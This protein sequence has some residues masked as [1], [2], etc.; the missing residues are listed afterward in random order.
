MKH[1]DETWPLKAVALRY[2]SERE[3]APRV[4]AKGER[5][6][7]EK[8][9]AIAQEHHIHVYEDPD[10]VALLSRLDVEAEIPHDLFQ[11]VAEVLAFVYRLN[12]RLPDSAAPG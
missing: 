2:D 10:L 7:A 6:L 5:L 9:I 4:V 11:A 8:I 12:N 3:T 1:K